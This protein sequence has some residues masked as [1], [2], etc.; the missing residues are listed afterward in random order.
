MK[1][2]LN[3]EVLRFLRTFSIVLAGIVL[4]DLIIGGG[5]QYLYSKQRSGPFYRVSYA[6]NNANA[7]YLVL[8]SSRVAHQYDPDIFESKLRSTFYNCGHDA[9]Y[10]LFSC[11]I[12]SAIIKRYSPKYIIFD[13][14]PDEFAPS[15]SS[16]PLHK[17]QFSQLLPYYNNPAIRPFINFNG[18]FERIKLI[19]KI[20]PYNSDLADLITGLDPNAHKTNK[21]YIELIQSNDKYKYNI[22]DTTKIFAEGSTIDS[23]AYHTFCNLIAELK[24]KNVTVLLVISPLAYKC[25]NPVTTSMCT[26]ICKKYSNSRFMNFTNKPYWFYDKYFYDGFHLNGF[27]SRLFSAEVANF[28]KGNDA[29]KSPAYTSY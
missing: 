23:V 17:A 8:G 24:K 26:L 6:I 21:G 13:I 28:I 3:P 4:F 14:M 12:A 29:V 19:S 9:H 11:A 15:S 2:N 10:L 25:F 7:S 18:N 16:V 22:V 1:V 27:G 20:Y 5:L